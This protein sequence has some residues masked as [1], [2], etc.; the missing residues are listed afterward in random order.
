MT[1]Y[2]EDNQVERLIDRIHEYAKESDEWKKVASKMAKLL[3]DLGEGNDV[4]DKANRLVKKHFPK[5][6]KSYE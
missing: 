1:N 3:M 6:Y 4:H 5:I 2:Y